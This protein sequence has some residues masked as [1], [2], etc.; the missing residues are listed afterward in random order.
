MGMALQPKR[1]HRAARFGYPTKKMQALCGNGGTVTTH[2]A[3]VTCIV[4][5]RDALRVETLHR[6]LVPEN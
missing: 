4:C 1:V 2:A 3:D 6:E 5:Q